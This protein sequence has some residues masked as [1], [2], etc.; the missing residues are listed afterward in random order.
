MTLR[1]FDAFKHLLDNLA[2]W[3]DAHRACSPLA[4][5]LPA[6]PHPIRQQLREKL[7]SYLLHCTD[8]PAHISLTHF[9]PGF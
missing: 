6:T 2:F 7:T 8:N 4:F 1:T 9:T 5:H 3:T